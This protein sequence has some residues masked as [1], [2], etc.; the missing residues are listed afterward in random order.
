[1]ATVKR[2]E[3]QEPELTD[4]TVVESQPA[5]IVPAATPEP[6]IAAMIQFALQNQI[7]PEGLEKLVALYERVDDRRAE[8]EFNDAMRQFQRKCP[9]VIKGRPVMSKDGRS[10]R[11]TFAP[12]EVVTET[13]RETEDACGFS[14]GFDQG[15]VG[16][17][18]V[19]AVCIVR[20]VG[21]HHIQTTFKCLIDKE[22]YMNETQKGASATSYAKRHALL[23]A[24]GIAP[25]GE[26]NDAGSLNGQKITPQQAA[27]LEALISEVGVDRV[28]FTQWL[29]VSSP[30]DLPTRDYQRAIDALRA[31]KNGAQ[32]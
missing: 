1:V 32:Q 13:I 6:S 21:G 5:A 31:R 11:Y 30:T 25:A 9:R 20:H 7:T 18:Y 19:T 22:A 2:P 15:E 12:L 4:I 14:H 3:K 26:D 27:D 17:D 10:V 24:Y 16:A 28:K 23:M 8:R 29:R